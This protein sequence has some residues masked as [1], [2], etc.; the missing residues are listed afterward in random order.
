MDDL[1]KKISVLQRVA[2]EFNK[3]KLLWAVGASLLLYF[4]GMVKSFNDIDIMVD[5]KD[6]E[7]CKNILL[8]MGSI[9]DSNSNPQYKTR[10]FMEFTVDEVE[11]DVMAGFVIVEDNIEHDC[12]LKSDQIVEYITIGGESVPLQGLSLWRQY[13][14]WMGRKTKVELIDSSLQGK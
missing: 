1:Q 14:E 13:Y 2:S 4:K 10:V 9:G 3:E 5:E 7:K 6:V 8:N 11:I 12:S